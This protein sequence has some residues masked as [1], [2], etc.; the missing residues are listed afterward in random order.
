MGCCS[1]KSPDEGV[2]AGGVG[3][4]AVVCQPPAVRED[5]YRVTPA[6]VAPQHPPIASQ[7]TALPALV[8]PGMPA[9]T[10][11]A[12]LSS[13]VTCSYPRPSG[14]TSAAEATRRYQDA[15]HTA[16]KREQSERPR[17][18]ATGSP[19]LRGQPS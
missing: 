7:F 3:V 5:W 4:F 17:A 19:E 10:S 9:P 8:V 6:E 13:G 11:W 16:G 15:A 18:R 14:R 2:P 12:F 1:W